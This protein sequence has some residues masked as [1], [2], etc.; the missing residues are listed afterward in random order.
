[1][2]ALGIFRL[3]D[4]MSNQSREREIPMKTAAPSCRRFRG[5]PEH[6]HSLNGER[7]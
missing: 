6:L 7:E 2:R 4:T 5:G 3:T 1:M